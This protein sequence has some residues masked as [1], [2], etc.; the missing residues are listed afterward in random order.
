VLGAPRR[1]IVNRRAR[2]RRVRRT[3]LLAASVLFAS[4]AAGAQ[5]SRPRPP[6]TE[7]AGKVFTFTRVADGVY[8]A[9]GTG[10]LS[11]GSNAVVVVN[12]RDVVLV[13][14]HVSP[15][16]AWT[17][18]EE[19]K[20]ITPNPV[21]TVINTHFHYDHTDG[22]QVYGPD[23]EII[24]SEFTRAQLLAGKSLQGAAYE[25]LLRVLM[26]RDDSLRRLVATAGDTAVK[27]EAAH[28]LEQVIRYQAAVDA[29]H[30]TAPTLTVSQQLVLH[31]G[32]REIRVLFLGRGHT[33]GDLFVFL[34]AER[35]L[36][37]G[38]FVSSGL[39][40]LGDG[41]LD[42]WVA[43]LERLKL[44]DFDLIL[45]GHGAPLRDRGAIDRLQSVLADF[46]GQA[47]A[48]LDAG[49]SVEDAEP[50]IDL[51]AHAKDYPVLADRTNP[52]VRQRLRI[53]L[54]RIEALRAARR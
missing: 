14:S 15:A 9:A 37:T 33:A 30:P 39:P 17:L 11:V 1:Q 36:A 53:G 3:A 28:R 7:H 22:N 52:D 38:D 13:D 18:L 34:P 44:L 20:E 25:G 31:R 27:C 54:Q 4:A 51:S 41:Y 29:V 49:V 46:S 5:P 19:L 42:E 26:Q 50:R 48:L 16:A 24:G 6:R 10:T 12:E 21:R 43:T 45:P 23:V 40:Y 47:N 2:R 35:V 32:A 8:H